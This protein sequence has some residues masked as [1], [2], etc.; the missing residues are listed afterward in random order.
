MA[1][2]ILFSLF[3]TLIIFSASAETVFVYI[4]KGNIVLNNMKNVDT[5]LWINSVEDGIVDTLFESGHIAFSNNSG[6]NQ[7]KN[8]NDLS[9]LAKSG[10]AAVMVSAVLNLNFTGNEMVIS[11]EYKVYNLYTDDIIKTGSYIF[12]NALTPAAV[13]EEKLFVAGQNVGKKVE[14]AL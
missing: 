12:N 5:V 4:E 3:F 7:I 2:K 13:V 10:G 8:F 11:G 6:K 9:Q 14:S 1:K